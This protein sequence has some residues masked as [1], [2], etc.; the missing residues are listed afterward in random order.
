MKPVLPVPKLLR[1][2]HHEAFQ[3]WQAAMTMNM[4]F[5]DN[6]V[7][8][9]DIPAGYEDYAKWWYDNEHKAFK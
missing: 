6:Y 1:W 3:R 2:H 8:V 9:P 5:G 4:I 7:T